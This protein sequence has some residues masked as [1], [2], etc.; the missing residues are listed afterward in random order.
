MI[1]RLGAALGFVTM[2]ALLTSGCAQQSRQSGSGIQATLHD[3]LTADLEV[4]DAVARTI[5]TLEEAIAICRLNLANAETTA[6]KR[7][8]PVIQGHADGIRIE[9]RRDHAQ[10]HLAPTQDLWD[11]GVNGQGFLV[12]RSN[13]GTLLYT[14]SGALEADANGVLT[15]TDGHVLEP[16]TAFPPDTTGLS[17]GIRG[18]IRITTAQSE[19]ATTVGQ[20]RLATFATPSRLE[21]IDGGRYYRATAAS[22]QP[23]FVNPGA[24]ACGVIQQGYLEQ[25]NV[26]LME[27]KAR[28]E[29]LQRTIEAPSPR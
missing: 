27:E 2:L 18:S 22:G 29:A 11:I 5:G 26:R 17:F 14:R 25:S 15:T 3:D 13:D 6:Y 20:L 23:I 1:A 19:S 16:M 8:R 12:V 9:A 21:A 24:E 4:R 7:T 10:G 28:I